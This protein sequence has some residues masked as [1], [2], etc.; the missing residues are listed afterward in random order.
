MIRFSRL[1]LWTWMF[2]ILL[3]GVDFSVFNGHLF[4]PHHTLNIMRHRAIFNT[5]FF[6]SNYH[7][8]TTDYIP[9]TTNCYYKTA[10]KK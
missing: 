2:W 9:T 8:L 7:R 10:N 1:E 5:S 3:L 4:I 6:L